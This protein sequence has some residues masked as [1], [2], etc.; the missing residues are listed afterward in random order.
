MRKS[1][2]F[3]NAFLNKLWK[4]TLFNTMDNIIIFEII[5]CD[6][7]KDFIG[8]IMLNLVLLCLVSYVH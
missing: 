3:L 5:A 1:I 4:E 2:Q 8:A 6:I 7:G